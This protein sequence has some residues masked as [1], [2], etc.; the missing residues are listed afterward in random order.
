MKYGTADWVAIASQ[1]PNRDSRQCRER[2]YHYLAPE[3]LSDE[4]TKEEDVLLQKQVEAHGH[5]WKWF[6]TQFPG[7][8]DINIKNHY[9][10]LLRKSRKEFRIALGLPLRL[11]GRKSKMRAV[12]QKEESQFE[13]PVVPMEC[14]DCGE[15]AD[16]DMGEWV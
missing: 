15:W 6:E 2:W 12:P 11:P 7:R 4:W 9:Q 13:N 8:T 16:L 5:K 3:V 1:M 10:L 14:M